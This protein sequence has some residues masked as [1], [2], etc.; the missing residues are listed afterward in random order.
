MSSSPSDRSRDSSRPRRVRRLF[1]PAESTSGV[2][3]QDLLKVVN[4]PRV[5]PDLILRAG[6]EALRCSGSGWIPQSDL[7]VVA[8]G[9]KAL[10]LRLACF[11]LIE[12][13]V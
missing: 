11:R 12:A 13:S 9:S 3:T 5:M 4:D 6:Q 8:Q 10:L 1:A 2:P 7:R